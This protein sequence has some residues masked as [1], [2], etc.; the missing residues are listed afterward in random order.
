MTEH[1][2]SPCDI[3]PGRLRQRRYR[4]V[5][6]N[7]LRGLSCGLFAL[8]LTNSPRAS[9]AVGLLPAASFPISSTMASA[10][11]ALRYKGASIAQAGEGIL[12]DYVDNELER[13]D[14]GGTADRDAPPRTRY[15]IA[16]SWYFGGDLEFELEYERNY[17]QDDTDDD[18][19]MTLNSELELGF[20][21]RPSRR[22]EAFVDVALAREVAFIEED[23]DRDRP[24]RLL[25]K[26]A[27]FTIRD[28]LEDLDLK[29]G[30]QRFD[31]EREWL[32][33]E[34]LD[35]VRIL[36]DMGDL[37]WEASASRERLVDKDLLNADR[38][39]QINNYELRATL[40]LGEESEIAAY[41]FYRDDRENL[42]RPA[43][44]LLFLGIQSN[45]ELTDELTYW[46][47]AAHVSGDEGSNDIDAFGFD[48]GI[49]YVFEQPYE[50]SLTLGLAYGSGDDN[51][52]DGTDRNFRQTDLQ[53][54]SA[55]L[56]GVTSFKYY[57]E[58]F[59]PEL[60][61]MVILTAGAGFRP[62]AE[63]SVDLVFHQ[64]WQNEASDDLRDVATDGDP[65]GFS[66]DLGQGID[67]VIGY[68]GFKNVELELVGGI[69]LPGG[70]FQDDD[71]P[72]FFAGMELQYKF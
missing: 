36:Y 31:D 63:S 2:R 47:E 55:K 11:E 56:N 1:R 59:D 37:E 25:L 60:S 45:G 53:D 51:P 50:P 10:L 28:L 64:Y 12:G 71:D 46:L 39:E 52:N 23:G 8:A 4:R 44:D 29:I 15:N 13:S 40:E 48:L 66:R 57:G 30:R 61:N 3:E 38:E 69:F 5:G 70:A 58:T 19:L 72:A 43:E 26:Q 14:I 32:Y 21:Y 35:A 22:F 27:N 41:A 49:T 18:D 62:T 67:L 34:E 9:Y 54:N 33:D 7:L 42:P 68:E 65:D 16:P 6:D 24:T 17:D 20:T